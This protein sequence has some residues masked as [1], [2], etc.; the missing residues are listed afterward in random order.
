MGYG[1]G[2]YNGKQDLLEQLRAKRRKR[3]AR[4]LAFSI[5]ATAGVLLVVVLAIGLRSCVGSGGE[6]QL[7]VE[8]IPSE[9]RTTASSEAG[10]IGIRPAPLHVALGS[11]YLI[12][13]MPAEDDGGSVGMLTAWSI[14]NGR[15][16]WEVP[17]GEP[18]SGV[19]VSGGNAIVHRED[20]N[21]LTA[22]AYR[23]T[24]GIQAWEVSIP[25]A[26]NIS[27]SNDDAR[28]ALAYSLADGYRIAIYDTV[29]GV[30]SSGKMLQ[31]A[32]AA[33]DLSRMNMRFLG[34][35]LLYTV[36]RTVGVL[37]FEKDRHWAETGS[38]QVIIASPDPANG[39]VYVLSWGNGSNSLVLHVRDI[40][41]GSGKELDRFETA[42]D[43]LVMVADDG[44]LLLACSDE[45]EPGQYDSTVRLFRRDKSE[46]Y[47][48][49]TIEGA[50]VED[51]MPLASGVFVLGLNRSTGKPDSPVSGGELHLVNATDGSVTLFEQ[52]RD[53]VEYTIRFGED[54]L[55]LLDNGEIRRV[56]L[57]NSRAVRVRRTDFPA[58]EP[59]FSPQMDVLGVL[60]RPV[61]S[62]PG[63]PGSR[64]QAVIFREQAP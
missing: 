48:R 27:I 42:A 50:R 54:R 53:N 22:R 24:D 38:A 13:A 21:G 1:P 2:S 25:G 52:M 47:V 18:L 15:Q 63:S 61:G 35:Q 60:S 44:Y 37:D 23:L 28:M 12:G 51:A 64:M 5:L 6:Q 29:Q 31:G 8:G 14:D 32:D 40:A 33:T 36:D 59:L 46:T 20:D 4:L 45:T 56:E 41:S 55:V 39:Q 10:E 17:V 49:Q 58:L 26:Q 3:Q 30:K 43:A 9:A 7:A 57:A 19:I 34:T 62:E 16:A 11:E